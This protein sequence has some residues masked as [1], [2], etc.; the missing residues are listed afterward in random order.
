[1]IKLHN[2]TDKIKILAAFKSKQP[3]A[4]DGQGFVIRSDFTESVIQQRRCFNG[5]CDQLIKEKIR[6][7]MA[8]PA[9]LTFTYGEKNFTFTDAE[10]AQRVVDGMGK[11][12]QTPK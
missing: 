12:T 6:F 7:R 4:H 9:T 10:E 3:L 5:V 8:F 11:V 1:M 2:Y